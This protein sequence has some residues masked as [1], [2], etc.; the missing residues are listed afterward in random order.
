MRGVTA[1]NRKEAEELLGVGKKDVEFLVGMYYL[2]SEK[3]KVNFC[4]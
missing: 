1:S 2:F 4:C 3:K